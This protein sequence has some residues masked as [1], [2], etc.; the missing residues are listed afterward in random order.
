MKKATLLII[1]MLLLTLSVAYAQVDLK[2]TITGS[3]T[4]TWGM[5]LTATGGTG[6]LTETSTSLALT[7]VSGSDT[8]GAE[9]DVYGTI[10]LS[11]FSIKFGDTATIDLSDATK[12]TDADGNE[13]S[14]DLL[15]YQAGGST[16]DKI[17][18]F[19][20]SSDADMKDTLKTGLNVTAPSI[21]AKI[22]LSPT[23]SVTIAGKP[24]IDWNKAAA[25]D[26]DI[27][28]KLN[29]TNNDGGVALNMDVAPAKICI[30]VVS[31]N[32]AENNKR[33][34]YAFGATV[35]VVAAPAT[36]GLYAGTG[37]NY[38]TPAG[39][40]GDANNP[41]GAGVGVTLDLGV[42]K[43]Y[44]GADLK[45][46][47]TPSTTLW[48]VQVKVPVAVDPITLTAE[49]TAASN[50]VTGSTI[51]ADAKVTAGVTASG[52]K[53]SLTLTLTDLLVTAAQTTKIE[54]S[55]SYVA[56]LSETTSA[57]PSVSAVYDMGTNAVTTND[58]CTLTAAVD[59]ALIPNTVF[60]IK[61]ASDQLLSGMTTAMDNGI[62]TLAAKISY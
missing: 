32:K 30:V 53:L 54:A 52:A 10:T 36:I 17:S 41:L 25:V 46:L 13:I 7:L 21:A 5:D 61:Y 55:A 33:N 34:A 37:I 62:I 16:I 9:A 14:T 40:V 31:E 35:D 50:G 11:D 58:S 47:T 8:K 42:I 15:Y 20:S 49:L 27:A 24:G 22:I 2:P 29:F 60:T 26:E 51:D 28:V 57:T 59:L 19:D 56:A 23:M 43:P 3:A 6:F 45:M 38:G 4:C 48:D 12:F 44:I 39:A 18:N 1:T